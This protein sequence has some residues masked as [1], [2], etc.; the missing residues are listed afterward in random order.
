MEGAEL[1]H[2]REQQGWTLNQAAHYLGVT[3]T[4]VHRWEASTHPVPQT[5]VILAH[6]LG[7]KRNR[8]TVESFLWK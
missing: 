4:S 8:R 3:K 1:K 2:W 7:E 6:L 5:I